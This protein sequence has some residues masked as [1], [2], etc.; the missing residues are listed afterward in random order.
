MLMQLKKLRV[1]KRILKF[2]KRS[3]FLSIGVPSLFVLFGVL[4]AGTVIVDKQLECKY[5][6]A[7]SISKRE[8]TLKEEHDEMQK[9]LAK[10][11]PVDKLDNSIPLPKTD[12]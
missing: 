11:T 5:A 6:R 9:M 7:S 1:Y 4:V 10:V 3:G 8:L 2:E 12:D